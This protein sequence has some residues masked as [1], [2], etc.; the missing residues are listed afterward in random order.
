MKH[1][2]YLSVAIMQGHIKC[3]PYWLY[4]SGDKSQGLKECG[5]NKAHQFLHYFSYKTTKT[6]K[7]KSKGFELSGTVLD[8]ISNG[9][10]LRDSSPNP[11]TGVYNEKVFVNFIAWYRSSFSVG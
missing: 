1:D 9:L 6:N 3:C 5:P 10:I 8:L 2:K 11:W 4:L 7:E